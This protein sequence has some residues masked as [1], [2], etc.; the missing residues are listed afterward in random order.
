VSGS[1]E[2]EVYRDL[3]ER[4]RRSSATTRPKSRTVKRRYARGERLAA[5]SSVDATAHLIV[6]LGGEAG[7]RCG[8]MIALE[9]REVDPGKRQICVQRSDWNGRVTTPKTRTVTVCAAHDPTRGGVPRSTASAGLD[10]AVSGRRRAA[11][12]AGDAVPGAASVA[13]SD[14]VSGRRAHPAS[15]VLLAR[16]DARGAESDSGAGRTPGTGHDSAVHA[17]EFGGARQCDSAARSG[18]P[19]CRTLE[20]GGV[21]ERKNRWIERLEMAVRQGFEPWVQLLGRTTV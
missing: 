15:H 19:S 7:L 11:D 12:S 21:S 1:V 13:P 5:A 8:E 2:N 9:W 20:T 17:P 14:A 10:R 6:L 16:G 18:W 4:Q 3:N